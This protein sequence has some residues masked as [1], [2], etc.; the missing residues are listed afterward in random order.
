M[1][2]V[3]EKHQRRIAKDI[4]KNQTPL[5]ANVMGGMSF[6]EAYK[7]MFNTDLDDRLDQ[8]IKDYGISCKGKDFSWELDDYGWNPI[9]LNHALGTMYSRELS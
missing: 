6:S 1:K 9:G 7:V 4:L 2:T 8:L 3:F 5:I